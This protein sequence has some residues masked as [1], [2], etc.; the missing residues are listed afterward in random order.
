MRRAVQYPVGP[1]CVCVQAAEGAGPTWS[2]SN[3][4][5]ARISR[6]QRTGGGDLRQEVLLLSHVGTEASPGSTDALWEGVCTCGMNSVHP[7]VRHVEQRGRANP[8][9]AFRRHSAP[10]SVS[11]WSS[12]SPCVKL[13]E[14]QKTKDVL[15]SLNDAL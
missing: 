2:W 12:S 4:N 1:V 3:R 6:H 13:K 7:A 5:K 9:H 8:L 11:V 14:E 10:P 15:P